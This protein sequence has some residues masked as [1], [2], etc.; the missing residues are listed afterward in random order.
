MHDRNTFTN[1]LV[2]RFV[3]A[4]RIPA[5]PPPQAPRLHASKRR[6]SGSSLKAFATER[7]CPSR[8]A[9]EFASAQIIPETV[10]VRQCCGW[11]SRAPLLAQAALFLLLVTL[12]LSTQ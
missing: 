1:F 2:R 12:A 11:D 6:W 8:R 10:G 7:G 4:N 9:S 3:R 5:V